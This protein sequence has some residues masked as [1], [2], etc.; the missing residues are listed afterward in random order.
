[1]SGRA[2]LDHA[3]ASPLRDGVAEAMA[4]W[5]GAADPGR[6]HTEGR[7]ARFALE[8]ARTSI[9]E[10]LGCRSSR[11][12]VLLSSLAEAAATMSAWATE[13]TP[14]GVVAA[15]A[16]EHSALRLSG[17][18]WAA[19][20]GG[21][22]VDL[23]LDPTA[24]VDLDALD[25]ILVAARPIA[26]V[27]IQWGNQETGAIQPIAEVI[28]RCRRARVLVHVDATQAAGRCPIDFAALDADLVTVAAPEVGGPRGVAALLVR[29]GLRL[30]PLLL[31]GAQERARRA[32]L[33][34]IAGAVGF[35]C[36][37]SAVDPAIEGARQAALTERTIAGLRRLDGVSVITPI[38]AAARLPH[39]TCCTFEGVEAEPVLLGLDQAG[40]AAHSGSACS[41]E[42]LEPS[43][44]LAAI[45]AAADRS[46]RTSVGWTST[47][48]D[49]D[50]YLAVLPE[51]LRSLL[52]LRS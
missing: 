50:R 31:G 4:P 12:V 45:G 6:V 47:E 52:A 29:R 36:A 10:S 30:D 37:L 9:A 2:Y 5:L 1:M 42:V 38:H 17:E 43:P 11:E 3:S 32:G 35:A 44:V 22:L 26:L 40:I 27:H 23:A 20:S 48:A 16:I 13:R 18:A 33:E 19:R 24:L 15:S 25:A 8:Q 14:G 46:L 34:D 28:G 7:T 21:G 49:V 51:V 41:S 39:L